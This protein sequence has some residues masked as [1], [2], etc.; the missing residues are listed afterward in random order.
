MEGFKL[1]LACSSREAEEPTQLPNFPAAEGADRRR[2][3]AAILVSLDFFR[4]DRM[5]D[6]QALRF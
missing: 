2:S 1:N 5:S 4:E 3:P 6:H